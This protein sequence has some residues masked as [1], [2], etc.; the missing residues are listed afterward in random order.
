LQ[1]S[2]NCGLRTKDRPQGA[3][4]HF[5]DTVARLGFE[6]RADSVSTRPLHILRECPKTFIS[7]FSHDVM[8]LHLTSVQ[9]NNALPDV[10]GIND[11]NAVVM[12]ALN[13][14]RD[15]LHK[16]EAWTRHTHETE[17]A[18]KQKREQALNR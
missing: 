17:R 2:R 7:D 13:V 3:D 12:D 8:R 14:V 6:V 16:V 11:Q 9:F 10:G 18:R 5:K 15:E 4:P 1:V